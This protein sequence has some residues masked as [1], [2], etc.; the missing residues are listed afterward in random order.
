MHSKSRGVGLLV[1]TMLAMSPMLINSSA[2]HNLYDCVVQTLDHCMDP[3]SFLISWRLDHI[4]CCQSQP[5]PAIQ[6]PAFP[7]MLYNEWDDTEPMYFK[8]PINQLNG[9]V[10]GTGYIGTSKSIGMGDYLAQP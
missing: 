4:N 7:L 8:A 5:K 6:S 9:L 1:I 10:G 2:W 3:S